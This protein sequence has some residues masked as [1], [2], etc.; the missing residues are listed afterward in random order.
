MEVAQ[1][2]QTVELIMNDFVCKNLTPEDFKVCF[3]MIKKKHVSKNFYERFDGQVI[4]ECLYDYANQKAIYIE[5]Q[6][7][8][9]HETK[10]REP[11]SEQVLDGLKTLAENSFY[12]CKP[13]RR[14]SH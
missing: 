8:I 5:Q 10:K 11:V 7:T 4:F 13:R 14:T 9:E 1:V 2:E 3:D 6:K 12:T